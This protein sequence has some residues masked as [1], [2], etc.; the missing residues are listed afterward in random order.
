MCVWTVGGEVAGGGVDGRFW[1]RVKKHNGFEI[2]MVR[3]TWL[4]GGE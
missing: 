1:T 2:G 4:I 3:D